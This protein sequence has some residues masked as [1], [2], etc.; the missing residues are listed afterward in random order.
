MN[1]NLHLSAVL[2]AVQH[3]NGIM[4]RACPED[5]LLLLVKGLR[6]EVH[7]SIAHAR[8]ANLIEG[9]TAYYITAAGGDLLEAETTPTNLNATVVHSTCKP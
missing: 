6:L 3:Y 7:A 5:V 4:K 1:G 9:D 2:Q 8:R